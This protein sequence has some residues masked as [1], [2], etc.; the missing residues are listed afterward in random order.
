MNFEYL[1]LRVLNYSFFFE[2]THGLV[3]CRSQGRWRLKCQKGCQKIKAAEFMQV[4]FLSTSVTSFNFTLVTKVPATLSLQKS[5][6]RSYTFVAN[7]KS[8]VVSG[9][10]EIWGFFCKLC[11]SVIFTL[12]IFLLQGGLPGFFLLPCLTAV[13]QVRKECSLQFS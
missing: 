8:C 3:S 12:N 5:S 13:T 7:S 9:G 11:F 10:K 1:R 6:E 4:S 2:V